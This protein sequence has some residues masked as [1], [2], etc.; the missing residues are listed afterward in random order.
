MWDRIKNWRWAIIITALLVAGLAYSFWPEAEAVD[1]G[2]V[3]EGPMEVG[4]TDDGVTRVHDLYTVTAPVTGYVTRIELDPG[5][6]VVAG[7]TVIA[8]MSGI[9]ST[10]LDRRT[11]LE[12][13][14]AIAA[15]RAG[16]AS[17]AATLRLAKA[18]LER[19]EALAER[20]FLPRSDLDA[21]RAAAATASSELA[22]IRAETKRLQSQLSEPAA[23]GLP[24]S[25]T[26]AVRSPESGV[27]L[28]RLVESEG[29]VAQG[30]ALVEIGDPARIEVVA[31][32]LSRE[33]AQIKPGDA[34][35]ITRW[36]G[37]DALPGRVRRIEP[38][39][40]L[41]I[42]AL[43][44][45]EQRVNVIIDFAP[46][47]ARQIAPLGHGY[48]IDAT[49]ILWRED[50]VVRVPVGALFRG[51][52]GGWQVFVEADGRARRRDVAI[53]HLNDDFAEVRDGLKVGERVV[54]NP[55]GNIEDGTRVSP[56]A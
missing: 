23:S 9:P 34:V 49:V 5:D 47:A 29:V 25:G 50:A 43:G 3:S 11:R 51:S 22:R 4:L 32:L 40:R 2:T 19:A 37:E 56:R 54:L 48:Q 31:D 7:Q 28:R 33:A 53:G 1:L 36:G 41:K 45:E 35:K 27:L 15:S 38:F 18:D 16:E 55:S 39:G 42:S 26:V 17:A 8:R 13:G 14:N 10:P 52:E 44:I 46:D 6:E 30:T 21:R 12:I 20:G 24:S